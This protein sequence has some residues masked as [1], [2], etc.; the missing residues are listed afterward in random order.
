MFREGVSRGNLNDDNTFATGGRAAPKQGV[1]EGARGYGMGCRHTPGEK[2]F[3]PHLLLLLP[4]PLTRISIR[5]PVLVAT[6]DEQSHGNVGR[7]V[8]RTEALPRYS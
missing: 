7:P 4:R 6:S 2:P 1:S 8:E 3:P 5:S